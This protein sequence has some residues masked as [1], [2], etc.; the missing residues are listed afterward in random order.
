MTMTRALSA[1]TFLTCLMLAACGATSVASPDADRS[2]AAA[3]DPEEPMDTSDPMLTSLVVINATQ[4]GMAAATRLESETGGFPLAVTGHGLLLAIKP[5]AI[6]VNVFGTL[7]V[8]RRDGDYFVM[9]AIV[10]PGSAAASK[11]PTATT[12]TK[13]FTTGLDGPT[14]ALQPQV[15]SLD[16]VFSSIDRVQGGPASWRAFGRGLSSL[17]IPAGVSLATV[18]DVE[19]ATFTLWPGL[20]T[21]AHIQLEGPYAQRPRPEDLLFTGARLDGEGSVAHH[22]GHFPWYGVAYDIDGVA[23]RQRLYVL[24]IEGGG[25]M[26]LKAQSPASQADTTFALADQLAADFDG[27]LQ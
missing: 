10:K 2:P 4:H 17:P 18:W 26:V 19:R 21:V 3:V 5:P 23:W 15:E 25:C 24:P 14:I 11:P 27:P 13:T 8:G 9:R 16:A 6:A 12:E 20:S 7:I 22:E 1:T